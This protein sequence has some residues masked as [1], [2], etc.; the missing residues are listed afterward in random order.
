MSLRGFL[1]HDEIFDSHQQ[2]NLNMAG[3]VNSC[4]LQRLARF[5]NGDQSGMRDS[6]L[7]FGDAEYHGYFC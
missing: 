7:P 2:Q 5:S 4:K 6:F 1:C 3:I